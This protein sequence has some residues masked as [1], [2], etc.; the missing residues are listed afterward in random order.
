MSAL[1]RAAF[2]KQSALVVVAFSL[3]ATAGSAQTSAPIRT[4]LFGGPPPTEV[5]SWLAIDPA[6]NVTAYIGKVELGTGIETAFAQLVA[7][8]LGVPLSA[9]TIVQ[10]ITGLTPD[11]GVTSGSQSLQSGSIPL[12]RAAAEA[13]LALQALGSAQRGK[14]FERAVPAQSPLKKTGFT[15]VGTPAPRLDIPAKAYGTFEYVQNVRVPGMWHAR[16]VR[17]A[18]IGAAFV[19]L[20]RDS[21]RAIAGARVVQKAN[22]VAVAAPDEWDAIRAARALRVTWS[23]GGLPA[24]S[25]LYAIVKKTP[26][27]DRV[28]TQR[29]DVDAALI[30]GG[31]RVAASYAWPFQTHGSIGPSCAVADVKTQ[32]A[33]IWSGTQGVYP[34]RAALSELLGIPETSIRVNYVE[35]SGCYGHNGADDAAADAALVSQALRR[36]VRVQWSRADEHGWD[37]KGPAMVMELE[38]ALAPDGAKIAAW[39][40]DVYT[41]THST[42]PN[43]DAGNLL[44]GQL[45]GIAAKDHRVNGGDRNAPIVYTIPNQRIAVHWQASAVLRPSALRTLGGAQN[46]FANESFFDELANAA[47]ADPLAFRLAHLE[48]PRAREVVAAAGKLA[49]WEPGKTRTALANGLVRG[50]GLAFAQYEARFAYVATVVDLDVRPATGEVL[51]RDVYVAHDCGLIVNP[52]G[53]RNQIEGNVLQASSRTLK[54]RVVFDR[55]R[56][57]SLDWKSY[58]ILRFSEIPNVHIALIDRPSEP[59][60]G[61]GEPTT[62]TI[63]PAIANAI[64][65]ACGARVRE[66]PLT[67]ARI[68]LALGR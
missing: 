37:P 32:S 24:Q 54:E 17:P 59:P 15:V 19:A 68:K 21:L 30:A 11:Q 14:R 53:L 56:V 27:T 60:L 22:F 52:D 63:A 23:G 40:N 33:T 26:S 1:E 3:G 48:D 39:R 5:D 58:P 16:V 35:A 61:A 57:T 66:V 46:S 28:A 38:G 18:K 10:G 31:K 64:F 50:R 20:D 12:R 65:A 51:L 47:G 49:G 43:N 8:E 55:A 45:L 4:N 13:R 34:L 9:V 6:G 67:P 42:R 7:D 29:G 44:A 2:L 36:P 41:P 62:C 25:E